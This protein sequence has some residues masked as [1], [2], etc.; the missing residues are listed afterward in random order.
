M[1]SQGEG[2]IHKY[3][4][5][6]RTNPA[7][8]SPY[9]CKD[10]ILYTFAYDIAFKVVLTQKNDE[11]NE[12][13]NAFMSYGLQGVELDYPKVDKQAYVVFKA[14]KH[15]K[16]YLLKYK[17]K[18]IVPYPVVRNIL[19]QRNFRDKRAKW[20]TNLQEYD[21]DIRTYKYCER[22]RYLQ[23]STESREDKFDEDE[24]I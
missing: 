18:V 17:T 9:F 14:V 24:F 2:I 19:V 7:L 4:G 1:G 6:D 15:F 13:P 22:T 5:R 20:M 21:L 23:V 12:F 10:F 16:L 8:M 3:Q 11:G